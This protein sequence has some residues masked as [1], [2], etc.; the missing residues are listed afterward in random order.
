M[1]HLFA[2]HIE[3]CFMLN[4]YRILCECVFRISNISHRYPGM[5][6]CIKRQNLYLQTLVALNLTI[7][8]YSMLLDFSVLFFWMSFIQIPEFSRFRDSVTNKQLA[9]YFRLVTSSVS[10]WYS[11]HSTENPLVKP[12]PSVTR[13]QGRPGSEVEELASGSSG[14]D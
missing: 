1:F 4:I 7:Q 10:L 6:I 8:V 3:A 9:R 11:K 12:D 13:S 2:S 14:N 5:S